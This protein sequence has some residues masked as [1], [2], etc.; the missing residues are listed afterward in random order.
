MQ[1]WRRETFNI[2]TDPELDAKVRVVGS[3]LS[4]PEKVLVVCINGKTQIRALDPTAPIL[5][6]HNGL[7][8]KASQRQTPSRHHE[9]VHGVQRHT[10]A[11][12]LD[13]LII[14]A[15]AYTRARVHSSRKTTPRHIHLK[16]K[17]WLANNPRVTIN[18]TPT[19]GLLMTF[20]NCFDGRD[21]QC[22]PFIDHDR[23]STPRKSPL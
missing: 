14:V 11:E 12:F 19:C 23:R 17:A 7:P 13:L 16:V 21:D 9:F 18:F 1:P 10:Q 20:E 6:M 5:P 15:K 22:V 2:S 8:E 4:P 3:Y